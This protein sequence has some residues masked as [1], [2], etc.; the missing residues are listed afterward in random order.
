MTLR[1][2]SLNRCFVFSGVSDGGYDMAALIKSLFCWLRHEQPILLEEI[3]EDFDPELYESYRN[4]LLP[5]TEKSSN[6]HQ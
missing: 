2:N 1:R 5:I 3:D 6:G 4:A